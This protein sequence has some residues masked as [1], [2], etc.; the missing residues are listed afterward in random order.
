[1]TPFFAAL[2]IG[3]KF[4]KLEK[5]APSREE[6][7]SLTMKSFVVFL[8]FNLV[9]GSLLAVL[10]IITGEIPDIST[11]L[12]L[13]L[14]VVAIVFS[15]IVYGTLYLACGWRTSMRAKKLLTKR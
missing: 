1:M 2:L 14:A 7:K 4:V 15:A 8:L 11:K 3:E 13:I 5:R 9:I 12:I 6:C 10:T